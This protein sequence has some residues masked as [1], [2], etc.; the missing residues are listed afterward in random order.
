MSCVECGEA[1]ALKRA[2][3]TGGILLSEFCANI[4]GYFPQK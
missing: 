1:A 4:Y 2:E 3:V